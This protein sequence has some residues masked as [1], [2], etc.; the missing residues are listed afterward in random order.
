MNSAFESLSSLQDKG[1][2]F[3]EVIGQLTERY[4]MTH[5]PF[6]ASEDR[7]QT[8]QVYN[9]TQVFQPANY[10]VRN[11]YDSGHNKTN[12]QVNGDINNLTSLTNH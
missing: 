11:N 2:E 5:R 9:I 7:K 10:T 6:V 1:S 12:T 4:A 8:M 3:D